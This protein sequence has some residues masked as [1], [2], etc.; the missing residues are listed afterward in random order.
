MLIKLLKPIKL[1][2]DDERII[3]VTLKDDLEGQFHYR[4]V[5]ILK[6]PQFVVL[7]TLNLSETYL[8]ASFWKPVLQWTIKDS[9]QV[10]WKIETEKG[11]SAAPITTIM[12]PKIR[13]FYPYKS[14]YQ[15]R[16]EHHTLGKLWKITNELTK[17]SVLLIKILY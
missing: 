4:V 1:V 12:P 17:K 13:K 6:L 16:I 7:N 5:F 9:F 10:T 3:P 8:R 14:N 2:G 11:S 15:T